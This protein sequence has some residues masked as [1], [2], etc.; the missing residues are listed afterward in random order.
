MDK[1]PF[2]P[3]GNLGREH[4]IRQL[5]D[6]INKQGFHDTNVLTGV[7]D[8][9]AVVQ[10]QQGHIVLLTSE[11]YCEGVDFDLSYMPLQHLGYK[12]VTAAVSDVLAMNGDPVSILV[13]LALPNKVSVEML[14][15]LY[16]G[17]LRAADVHSCSINGGDVTASS[18][19]LVITITVMGSAM[20]KDVV[21][22]SGARTNDAVCVTGDFGGAY[23]GLRILLREKHVWGTEKDQD[24][25]QPDFT[26]YEY[27]MKRQLAPE[28]RKDL[29]EAMR[30]GGIK[31]SAM[32]DVS[33]NLLRD[34]S[35][36]TLAS[37]CGAMIYQAA[38]PIALETRAV[39]DELG[40][41]V[42]QYAFQGGEDYELLFTLPEQDVNK[43][44]GLFKDFVVIGKI[45]DHGS[46]I[47][48]QTAS[49]EI[50]HFDSN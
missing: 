43:L 6:K 14:E 39:A 19:G 37:S 31:P 48:L 4:L 46:G 44:V 7:G 25:F 16:D 13:N 26:E 1:A 32:I 22:R 27:V 50:L 35:A 10:M 5:A 36:L 38:I 3:V 15:I 2:T 49:G 42:D 17:L 29:I 20:K 18:S 11:T 24:G 8:D 40:E 41:D 47:Q 23:A 12:L 33:K 30:S 9:T 21:Y 34:L 45:T 28:S